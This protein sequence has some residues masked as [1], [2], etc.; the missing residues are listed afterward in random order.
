MSDKKN[1]WLGLAGAGVLI[2]AALLMHWAN[3]GG[4][5]DE[6]TPEELMDELKAQKLDVV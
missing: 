5:E 1:L 6:P 3:Q 2:G 4:E